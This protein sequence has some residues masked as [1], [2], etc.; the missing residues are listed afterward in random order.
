M[1]KDNIGRI[2]LTT[3]PLLENTLINLEETL[4][5]ST[6]SVSLAVNSSSI[7]VHNGLDKK[8]MECEEGLSKNTLVLAQNHVTQQELVYL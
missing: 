8:G 2:I 3:K 4:L 1:L 6:N 7:K 5:K